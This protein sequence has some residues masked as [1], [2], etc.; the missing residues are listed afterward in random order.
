MR[1]ATEVARYSTI[2]HTTAR[3]STIRH[4]TVRCSMRRHAAARFNL[5][6]RGLCLPYETAPPRHP[7]APAWPVARLTPHGCPQGQLS[8]RNSTTPAADLVLKM[9]AARGETE[10]AQGV[11]DKSL[12]TGIEGR[13]VSSGVPFVLANADMLPFDVQARITIYR[14]IGQRPPVSPV[15]LNASS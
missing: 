9:R 8:A 14:P 12:A 1:W 5:T 2:P 3:Y 11:V 6:N 4:T 13:G 7:P 10:A 15:T